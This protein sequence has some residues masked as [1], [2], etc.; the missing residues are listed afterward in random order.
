MEFIVSIIFL[1]LIF[2]LVLWIGKFFLL[3]SAKKHGF[4]TENNDN[5]ETG[6]QEKQKK[7]KVFNQ[8]DGEYVDFEEINKNEKQN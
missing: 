4:N 1:Y 3:R 8:S 2:R 7:K 6:R 5:D